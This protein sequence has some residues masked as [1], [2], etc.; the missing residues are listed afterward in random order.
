MKNL[1]ERAVLFEDT[2]LLTCN[3]IV[4]AEN[5][6]DLLGGVAKVTIRTGGIVLD[7]VEKSLIEEALRVTKYNQTR[8]AKML[9]ISRETLKY[10]IKKYHIAH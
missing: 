7:D 2:D 5:K 9:N 1:I 3:N 6:V 8:A 10:R 4:L